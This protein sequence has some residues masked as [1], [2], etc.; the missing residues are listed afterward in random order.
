MNIYIQSALFFIFCLFYSF[1]L[2]Q[3]ANNNCI[4]AQQI[5]PGE[6]QSGNNENASSES[7]TS[8]CFSTNNTIWYKFTTNSNGGDVFVNVGSTCDAGTQVSGALI[9]SPDCNA[10]N[11]TEIDCNS[12]SQGTITFNGFSL[13]PH[14]TYYVVVNSENAGQPSVCNYEINVTGPGIAQSA[15][16]EIEHAVC[17]QKKG[18]LKVDSVIMGPGP[19]SYSIN[20]STPQNGNSFSDLNVGSYTIVIT[21][22]NGCSYEDAISINDLENTLVVDA[23]EDRIIIE[24]GS[25]QL[26]AQ[27]NGVSYFW[28]PPGGLN[29]P[30]SQS[31]TASPGGTTTYAAFTYSEELCQAVDF[32]TVTVLPRIVIPNTF[33]PNGD[34]VNDTWQIY[35][36]DQYPD[37]VVEIYNRW[38]QK[39]FKSKGYD[40]TQEWDGQSMGADLPASTYYFVIDLKAQ[41]DDKSAELYRGS[42]TIIR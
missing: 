42:I 16:M 18:S 23:G 30:S 37:C 33:T 20:D 17:F 34:G 40:R 2:A 36:I 28:Q 22:A 19:Y 13:N 10:A 1:A 4:G 8:P 7:W 14:T 41:T 6:S 3:P 29:E 12:G 35:F 5:C 15:Y 31:P 25:V 38:G 32:M 27:G 9:A 24:G 11:F 21:D 26:N 39:V